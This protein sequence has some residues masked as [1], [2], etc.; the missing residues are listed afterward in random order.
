[1]VNMDEREDR[2][3]RLLLLPAAGVY[4]EADAF[5]TFGL[6]HRE[7]RVFC[8]SPRCLKTLTLFVQLSLLQKCSDSDKC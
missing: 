7:L 2:S 1:M 4:E 5:V 6:V 3:D 8:F